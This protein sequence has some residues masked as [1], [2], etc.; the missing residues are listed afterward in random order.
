MELGFAD[1][2]F[3]L[4]NLLLSTN[5]GNGFSANTINIRPC[6]YVK[7]NVEQRKCFLVALYD[8]TDLQ[9]GNSQTRLVNF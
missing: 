3:K 8:I 6:K 5:H 4:R 1:A 7:T 9:T 2:D